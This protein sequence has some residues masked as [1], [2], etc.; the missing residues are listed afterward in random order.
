[1]CAQRFLL[2]QRVDLFHTGRCACGHILS[3]RLRNQHGVFES[4]MNL[5]ISE[6]QNRFDVEDDTRFEGARGIRWHYVVYRDPYRV[7]DVTPYLEIRRLAEFQGIR[8]FF[9]CKND[10][11]AIRDLLKQ[12]RPPGG[13]FIFIESLLVARFRVTTA[14]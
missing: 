13:K 11:Y 4:Q 3:S 2:D 8:L 10:R 9:G 14:K 12:L 6:L 7:P 5:L 1:M